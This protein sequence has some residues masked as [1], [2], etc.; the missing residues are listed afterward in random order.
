[1]IERAKEILRVLEEAELNVRELAGGDGDPAAGS[2]ARPQGRRHRAE[3][4]QLKQL[5]P[6]PQLD[7]FS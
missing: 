2:T 6:P 3:R 7:L 1:M 5:A 4:D